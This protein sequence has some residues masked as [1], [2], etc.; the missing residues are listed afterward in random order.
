[1]PERDLSGVQEIVDR[2]EHVVAMARES[3]CVCNSARNPA[4]VARDLCE[5]L[6]QGGV[7]GDGSTVSVAVRGQ[8][9]PYHSP[10]VSECPWLLEALP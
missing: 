8:H 3:L 4:D 2:Y 7:G 6:L 1:M 10:P 9:C 5:Y